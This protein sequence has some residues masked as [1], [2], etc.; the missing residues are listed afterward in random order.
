MPKCY[1]RSVHTEQSAIEI[2]G[3]RVAARTQADIVTQCTEWLSG[4]ILRHIVTA[5][6]EI[7]LAARRNPA[8][9]SLLNRADLT[10]ADGIGLRWAAAMPR[11]QEWQHAPARALRHLVQTSVG[12]L[13]NPSTFPSALPERV[14]GVD[15][16]R[17]I[18]AAAAEKGMPVY[19]LGGRAEAAAHAAHTLTT[20]FP[21]LRVS[22]SVR[23]HR[24]T[25]PA[26]S[27]ILEDIRRAAPAILF[28]GYGAPIQEQ[29]IA[30]HADVLP[31]VK[32]AMGVGGAF[33]ILAGRLPRAPQVFQRRGME[34]L[35][36]LLRE[37]RRLPRTVRA[38]L[39][40]PGTILFT[41]IRHTHDASR[42]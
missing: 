29:W 1:C 12:F 21:G 13:R 5:N 40:F 32:L 36:R 31:S 17:H 39:V 18:A 7:L 3:V 2:L 10:T 24:A 26:D 20:T 41:S 30:Y 27:R 34:W 42:P 28:V 22:A 15:L 35:W 37:P 16:L 33:D 8:Y 25:I 11:V 23:E 38:T 9:R 6:P 19:L 14:A 4:T